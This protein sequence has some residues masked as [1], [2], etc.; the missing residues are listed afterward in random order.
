ML[1]R[2]TRRGLTLIEVLVLIVVIGV[3]L[4]LLMPPISISHEAARRST[5]LNNMKGIG[6][7]LQN[8]NNNFASL[9]GSASV[10]AGTHTVNGLSFLVRILPFMEYAAEPGALYKGEETP[11]K[12]SSGSVQQQQSYTALLNRYMPMFVC[13]SN[14]NK[15]FLDPAA[16]PAAGA[17]TNYKAMGGTFAA[18]LAMAAD[19]KRTPPYDPDHP[20]KF[21]DGTMFPGPGVRFSDIT[22][23]TSKTIAVAETIDDVCSRWTVGKEVTMFGLPSSLAGRIK[24]L[25]AYGDIW[26]PGD[27]DGTFGPTSAVGLNKSERPYVG[28]DF[29]PGGADYAGGGPGSTQYAA[30][31]RSMDFGEANPPNYGPSSAHPAGVNHLFVDG[32]VQGISKQIDGAAYMF[33]ITRDNADPFPL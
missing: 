16:H 24:Q 14:P 2:R 8:Y 31:D 13:P 12:P 18:A 15:K 11:E 27:F 3:L 7:G 22:D 4:A 30:D 25:S 29:S 26:G 28:F 19:V 1:R 33:L 21:P 5:C 20:K 23:G 17:L 9:P 32:S 6:L 10:K